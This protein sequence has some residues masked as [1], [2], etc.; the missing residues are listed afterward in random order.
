[1]PRGR[2]ILTERW[3]VGTWP[4]NLS[5]ENPLHETW[6]QETPEVHETTCQPPIH[7]GPK[8]HVPQ[9][10]TASPRSHFLYP[11]LSCPCLG[12]SVT[13]NVLLGGDPGQ[14]G[15]TRAEDT[16][17]WGAPLTLSTWAPRQVSLAEQGWAASRRKKHP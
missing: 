15:V 2:L 10:F 13:S 17:G 11:F 9:L 5:L 12:S 3:H 1:M 6:V 8:K 7:H 4:V 14:T 16:S